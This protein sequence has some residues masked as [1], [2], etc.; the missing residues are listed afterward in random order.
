MKSKFVG[1]NQF[2]GKTLEE[3]FW[4]KVDIR[5]DNECWEWQGSRHHKW[6][7][8]HFKFEGKTE[9]A[10][11]ISWMLSYGKYPELLVLHTCDNPPCVNPKHLF[12]GTN[13]DNMKDM[14]RKGRSSDNRGSKNPK[15]KL[16][17]SDVIQI[18]KLK[19]QVSGAELGR[20][21]GVVKEAIYDIWSGKHWSHVGEQYGR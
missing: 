1:T 18:K 6:K 13:D 21:F 7:Y 2:S 5:S 16:T 10:H 4:E 19:G 17:E 11:R 3:R 20:K 9:E 14:A 8:G 12:L 15:A